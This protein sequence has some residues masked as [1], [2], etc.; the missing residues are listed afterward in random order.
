LPRKQKKILREIDK[1]LSKTSLKFGENV[2][3]T[4]GFQLHMKDLSGLPE[5]TIEAARSLAKSQE[6]NGWILL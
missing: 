5:G 3:E 4:Q 1:E 6:S 2:L